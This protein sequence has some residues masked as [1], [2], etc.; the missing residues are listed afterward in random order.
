[1]SPRA[2]QSYNLPGASPRAIGEQ[3]ISTLSGNGLPSSHF[4]P[5][6]PTMDPQSPSP[7]ALAPDGDAQL[8]RPLLHGSEVLH[9]EMTLEVPPLPQAS[10]HDLR[11]A[12]EDYS[13]PR[14]YTSHPSNSPLVAPHYNNTTSNNSPTIHSHSSMHRLSST[15]LIRGRASYQGLQAKAPTAPLRGTSAWAPIPNLPP[16]S[17]PVPPASS[18]SAAAAQQQNWTTNIPAPI[19]PSP[20]LDFRGAPDSSAPIAPPIPRSLPVPRSEHPKWSYPQSSLGSTDWSEA[21]AA[22]SARPN[23]VLSSPSRMRNTSD[24]TPRP[25][26]TMTMTPTMQ[27][28]SAK[29][30]SDDNASGSPSALRTGR[31]PH[32]IG[33]QSSS[34]RSSRSSLSRGAAGTFLSSSRSSIAAKGKARAPDEQPEASPER[35]PYHPKAPSGGSNWVMWV[36]NVPHDAT[37]DEATEFFNDMSSKALRVSSS[38]FKSSSLSPQPSSSSSLSSSP[39]T[40]TVAEDTGIES[41]FLILQSHCAF[42]NYNSEGHLQRALAYFNGRPFRPGG[43]K[44]VCRIR[45]KAEEIKSGVGGQRGLGLHKKWVE[46]HVLN[47]AVNIPSHPHDQDDSNSNDTMNTSSLAAERSTH[48]Q[49]ALERY[50]SHLV[51]PPST[52]SEDGAS[53]PSNSTTSSLL[54]QYFPVRYFVLKAMTKASFVCQL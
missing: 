52:L 31:H 37:V 50:A 12:S 20:I 54:T 5:F 4:S 33:S 38:A 47:N 45:R 43:V 10:F 42:V 49:D 2:P 18:A 24:S 17:G 27:V 32:S 48:Y 30:R 36:G 16:T 9:R 51:R 19:I 53:S 34:S 28:H 15:G 22:W 8:R 11:T 6:S 1:M 3:S 21:E 26:L 23:A 14:G 46:Q 44:L 29:A 35:K 39:T 7:V 25:I 41:I 40:T 13:T